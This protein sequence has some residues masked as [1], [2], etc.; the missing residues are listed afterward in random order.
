MKAMIF[1]AGFGK[2]MMPLSAVLPKALMPFFGEPLIERTILHL[3]SY[4]LA[5]FVI[6]LHHL[7]HLIQ[8]RLGD[9][10]RLGVRISYSLEREILGTAGG[11]RQALFL[12]GD[13]TFLAINGDVVMDL[14]VAE[15]LAF[16][17]EKK[18]AATLA[19]WGGDEDSRSGEVVV[20]GEGKVLKFLKAK[21][22]EAHGDLTP[23]VFTGAQLLEAELLN[24]VPA[25]IYS[26]TTEGFYQALL[27]DGIPFYGYLHKGYWADIGTPQSYRRAQMELLEAGGLKGGVFGPLGGAGRLIERDAASDDEEA[28]KI[29]APCFIGENCRLSKGSKLGR[30]AVLGSNCIIQDGASV[31]NSVLWD[32]IEIGWRSKAEG[33]VIASGVKVAPGAAFRD[34]VLI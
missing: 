24:R 18:S 10:S 32:N 30:Y 19:L 7:G 21:R 14:D 9:G 25:G 11:M 16:H 12:L 4:G 26:S 2:R 8:E 1:A 28:V 17:R 3:R 15:F 29:F 13:G 5:E 31:E 27:L 34:E 20:D 22:S 6:N 23:A 33:C